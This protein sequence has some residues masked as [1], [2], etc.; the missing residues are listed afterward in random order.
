MGTG[1]KDILTLTKQLFW[2]SVLG[3]GK[4]NLHLF[5]LTSTKKE[6]WDMVGKWMVEGKLRTVIEDDNVFDLADTGKAIEKLKT[7]R[8]RG[9]IVVKVAEDGQ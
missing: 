1:L 2:P 9:K 8:T 4:R 3:G 7:G 5:M 6:Q